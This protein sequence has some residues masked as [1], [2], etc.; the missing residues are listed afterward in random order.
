MNYK[1]IIP[2]QNFRF[3]ILRMLGWIPSSIMLKLQ[4]YIKFN[5]SLNIKNPKRF[6]EKIQYYKMYY[7]NPEMHR[8]VDKY[9]VRNFLKERGCEE[10]LNEIYGVYDNALEID[11]DKLP[12]K[13]VIK[14]TDGSG[15]ENILICKDKTSL[16]YTNVI[17]TVNGWL[18][19]NLS[20]M[21][22][23][24]A[25]ESSLKSRIIIEKYLEEKSNKDNAID[26][27]KFFC[28]DGVVKYLV[29]DVDRY[30][31]HKRNFYAGDWTLL[32]V[33]SDCPNVDRPLN[34]PL[35]FE[36]MISV[37]EKLSKGFPFVRV[38]LYFTNNKVVFGEM[39]F[40]PWSGYVQFKPDSFDYELGEHFNINF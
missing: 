19:K 31:G 7:C 18:N 39:T 29:V 15:G 8:C 12:N 5:R 21:T 38:D 22:R 35:G 40:Y 37:A 3:F 4:Y 14:S 25:Y 16:N 27:Y 20:S 32:N 9:L 17:S 26:D 10:Y 36:E 34:K 6:T 33:S 11:F 24:W 2:S 1:T 13:F 23:E 28:F 30:T